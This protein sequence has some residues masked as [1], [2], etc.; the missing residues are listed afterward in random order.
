MQ[1]LVH[2]IN[3]MIHFVSLNQR[4]STLD[5]PHFRSDHLLCWLTILTIHLFPHYFTRV[6]NPASLK[7]PASHREYV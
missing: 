3:S 1:H 5:S 6:F 2:G 7:L 4:I